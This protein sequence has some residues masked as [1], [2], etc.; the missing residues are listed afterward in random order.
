MAPMETLELGS[1]ICWL[2]KLFGVAPSDERPTR[3]DLEQGLTLDRPL[4]PPISLRREESRVAELTALEEGSL[5][6]CA[7][8]NLVRL[9][10]AA[11]TVAPDDSAD[12]VQDDVEAGLR[13]CRFDDENCDRESVASISTFDDFSLVDVPTSVCVEDALEHGTLGT[14]RCQAATACAQLLCNPRCSETLDF[15]TDAGFACGT[16]DDFV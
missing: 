5:T 16:S 12:A 6:T 15:Y 4:P 9:D 7:V 14:S 13:S 11:V 8:P 1:S 3:Q 2:N 10:D